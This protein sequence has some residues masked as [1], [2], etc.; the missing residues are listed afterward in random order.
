M[1]EMKE[2][3]QA[4]A[5]FQTAEGKLSKVDPE[6]KALWIT[7][8]DGMERQFL[9]TDQTQVEGADGTVESLAGENGQILRIHFE[10]SAG[11]DSA[12]KIEVLQEQAKA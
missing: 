12:I 4:P 6:T 7:T 1:P 8:A 3:G 5:A 9:Y 10:S 2:P 11:V